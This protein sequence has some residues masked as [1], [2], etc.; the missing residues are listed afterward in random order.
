[1]IWFY[2]GAFMLGGSM[3]PNFLNNYLYSGQE[4]ADRGNVIV[5]TVG[6]RVGVL[7]FLSSGDSGIPGNDISS[8]D[9][10][11]LKTLHIQSFRS[12]SKSKNQPDMSSKSVFH[13]GNRKLRPVG[14][15]RF[16]RLGAQEHPLVRWRP[17]KHHHLWRV[18]RW[19]KCQLPGEETKRF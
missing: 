9:V 4:I 12:V 11:M 3:G 17:W 6:Y 15:A 1:M 13:A 7:G 18:C 2:G 8:W 5:V 10:I 14:P 19:C 16:H